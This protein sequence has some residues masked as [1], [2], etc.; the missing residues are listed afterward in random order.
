[1]PQVRHGCII[2]DVLEHSGHFLRSRLDTALAV[3]D[4]LTLGWVGKSFHSH[5]CESSSSGILVIS[6][7]EPTELTAIL[8]H[9]SVKLLSESKNGQRY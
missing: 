2:C 1:M 8:R 7:S 5:G 4:T 3:E 6:T 9:T